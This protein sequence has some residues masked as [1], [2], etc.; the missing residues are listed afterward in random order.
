MSIKKN[1]IVLG[2]SPFSGN[3]GVGALAYS[4]IYIIN[5]ISK[6]SNVD[7]N[8]SAVNMKK[9]V[10]NKHINIGGDDIGLTLFPFIVGSGVSGVLKIIFSFFSSWRTIKQ[11]DY[12][13]D[14]GEGDSFSDI[15][16]KERFVSINLPKKL[17]RLLRKKQLLLPQ[18][19]GPFNNERIAKEARK[20]IEKSNFVMA[21]DRMSYNYVLENTSQKKVEELIDVAFFMPYNKKPFDS[22]TINVGLNISSLMW[23]GGYTQNNQF[24]FNFS[25]KEVTERI[26]DFF[27][28]NPNVQLHLVPHVVLP[29]SDV[30]NDYEISKFLFN[31][32]NTEKIT[33]APFFLDPIEAK[34]YISGLDFFT[35]ARMHACIAAFSSGVPVYPIAYSRKFN[36]LFVE[37]LQYPYLG[38]LV[39]QSSDDFFGGL[40]Y[41]FSHKE[42]LKSKIE[43][44]LETIV[45]PRYEILIQELKRFLDIE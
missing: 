44:S 4:T 16:G 37:T 18:T 14:I 10:E 9:T 39:N 2:V 1:I 34:S 17:F 15:Y 23:H 12:I 33:L 19:I 29:D 41:A 27:L 13:L 24:G 31:K 6:S 38:D 5:Q 42:E 45:A 26:I 43:N 30:E 8:L 21:R 25:Y 22:S 11:A 7:V 3:R 20:S 40:E 28:A 35:G 36:G 32:Y